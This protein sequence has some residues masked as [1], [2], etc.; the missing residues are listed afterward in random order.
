MYYYKKKTK[1]VENEITPVLVPLGFEF[2]TWQADGD[3]NAWKYTK[4]NQS[5]EILD[6]FTYVDMRFRINSP[7]R[8]VVDA[9]TLDSGPNE[10]KCFG[11]DY[12][13]A[14]EFQ[15]IILEFR[16]IIIERGIKKLEE[17]CNPIT[18]EKI[19]RQKEYFEKL[20]K[21]RERAVTEFWADKN[22]EI[23]VEKLGNLT[24]AIAGLLAN[25]MIESP[26]SDLWSIGVR[27]HKLRGQIFTDA[28]DELINLAAVYGDW[29][30]RTYGGEW[31][32]KDGIIEVCNVG[33]TG[34][35]IIPT[36]MIFK[37]WSGIELPG[38]DEMCEKYG[39]SLW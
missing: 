26:K 14:E 34:E 4:G 17:L 33:G 12:R 1:Y 24:P 39:A 16:R 29:I 38:Y 8:F 2:E 3:G 15:K 20:E 21:N 19:I 37:A 30:I 35:C 31:A 10:N 6:K 9:R 27:I 22:A 36:D 18:D 7:G 32:N 5:I 23:T 13:S 11:Y 25:D 28:V